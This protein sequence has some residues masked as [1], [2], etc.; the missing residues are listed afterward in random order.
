MKEAEFSGSYIKGCDFSGA[1]LTGLAVKSGAFLKNTIANVVWNRTSFNETQIADIVFV[2]TLEDC[3]FENC[4][5]TRVKFQNSTLINTFFKNKKR[6]KRI[7]FIDCK[8]D[9]MTYAF[10]KNGKADL[11]GIKLLT[12]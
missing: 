7:Q 12:A 4:V 3:F 11:S 6:L 9:N 2:G 8:V 5:F 1:D 10:L